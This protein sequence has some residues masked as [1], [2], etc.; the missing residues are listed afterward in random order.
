M[1]LKKNPN[2]KPRKIQTIASLVEKAAVD[3]QKL[4]R[5]KASNNRGFSRC[6]SCSKWVHYKNCDAGH[7]FSRRHLRLKLYEG[8][9]AI[10]CKGCN[11]RMGCPTVHD[12]YRT[13][14]YDMYGVRRVKAMK[15]LTKWS[16]PKFNME[17]VKQFRKQIRGQ[18]KI[19]LKRL[20]E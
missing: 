15:R 7:Y 12:E 4:V 19:Q 13:Y 14:M 6:V 17:Q 5:L 1:S 10:Q 16:K 18:I 9:I 3:L 11:M 2:R 8:N 20:G